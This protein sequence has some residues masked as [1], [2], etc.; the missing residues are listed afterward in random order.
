M[1]KLK[2]K[3]FIYIIIFII[4]IYISFFDSYSFFKLLSF[5]KKYEMLKNDMIIQEKENIRLKKENVDLKEDLFILEKKAREL[6][7]VKEG[8]EIYK[9]KSENEKGS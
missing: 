2:K 5:R 4:I 3:N 6:G 9:F 8:E 7:M 1:I